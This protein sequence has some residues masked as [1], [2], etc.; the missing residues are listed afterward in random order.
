[1]NYK[2]PE[3]Q[4]SSIFAPYI[5]DYI[6][7]R[8][9]FGIKFITQSN[10]LRQ[11]DRYCNEKIVLETVLS[12]EL[13]TSWTSTKT[14]EKP[15]T[16]A[17][18]IST[19][20]CFADYFRSV[21]GI[22]TW[23]PFPGYTSRGCRYVPYIYSEDEIRRI[24]AIAEALPKP[25]GRSMF[26]LV[27]PAVLKVLYCCG[28][29]VNEALTL[30][31]RDVNLQ[32]GFI[33]IKHAKFENYRN[34][35]VSDSLLSALTDYYHANRELIGV[36]A[37]GFFFPNADGER[38]SQR[39]VYDKFR[40][41]LWKSGVPHRG[42]GIGPRV[43]DLRHTFA[44]RSLRK[45]IMAGQDMYVSI[46][47][48]MSYLGHSKISSTEYYLRFTSEMFPEFLA[49]ADAVSAA[50]IPEVSDYDE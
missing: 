38:Y 34:L 11:F 19:L 1:M 26:H 6:E 46:P 35:P 21:G 27:F 15:Q 28:L 44:V 7:L 8:E 42:K 14:Q 33:Y 24:F 40:T 47:A 13:V 3:F 32:D 23:N 43:H 9:S 49:K 39:T 48:L 17:H 2:K 20:K 30:R 29:R 10:L 12:G 18:R 4:F 25:R 50:V 37:E 22:V 16:H 41:I 36:S 5:Y 31:V 45:N